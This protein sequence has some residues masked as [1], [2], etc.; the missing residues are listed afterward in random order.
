MAK[1]NKF[2]LSNLDAAAGSN[3]GADVELLHPATLE[4]TGIVI[5]VMGKDGDVYRKIIGNQNRK[6]IEAARKSRK[7]E[8]DADKLDADVVSLLADCTI[9]WSGVVLDGKPLECT[10]ENAKM[11]YTR[12]AWIR[13]QIDIA[14]NDRANFMKG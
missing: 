8:I 5:R 4:K 12:F 1:S 7:L 10:P 6:R 9:S 14:V 3:E 2:D 11:V 13:E